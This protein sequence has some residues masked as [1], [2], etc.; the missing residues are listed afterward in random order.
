E[1][2]RVD[3]LYGIKVQ[4]TEVLY[5]LLDNAYEAI[6]AK[7]E[8]LKEEEKANYKGKIKIIVN[9]QIRGV[10]IEIRDNGIGI[11]GEDKLKIFAPFFTTKSSYKPLSKIKSGTGIGMYVAKRLIEESH[12]GRIWFESEYNKGTTFYIELPK[13]RVRK[14]K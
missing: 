12:K 11:K 10:I 6:E 4:I 3:N 9:G 13:K 1:D 7:Y 14:S 5:N 8:G 2:I